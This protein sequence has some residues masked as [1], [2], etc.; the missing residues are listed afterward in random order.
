MLCVTELKTYQPVYF[1]ICV[2]SCGD[3]CHER[4][5][6]RASFFCNDMSA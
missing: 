1:R 4:F 5:M 3:G 2:I 6:T